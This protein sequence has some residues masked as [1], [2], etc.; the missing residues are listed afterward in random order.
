M[1]KFLRNIRKKIITE[2][3]S[4]IKNTNYIKYAFG[5][6]ILVM[7][8]ILLALQ[9]NNWNEARK[10]TAIELDI[11]NEVRNGLKTDLADVEYNLNAQQNSLKSQQI[12]INWLES[13]KPFSDSLSQHME[14]IH[15]GTF[16]QSNE[17]PY[18]TLKQLGMRTITNDSLRNQI[19]S[20]YDLHYQQYNKYNDLYEEFT[21]QLI[22]EGANDLNKV[23]YFGTNTKPI[24][25][26]FFRH[27]NR[28]KFYLKTITDFNE[29]IVNQTIPNIID[30]I[31]KTTK[32]IDEEI[33]TRS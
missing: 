11:L 26:E 2:N 21:I 15:Y 30:N 1:I 31:K 20:L 17:S 7:V 9:V 12:I 14:K 23:D 4:V 33:K 16:F 24:N 29:I 25:D 6:I 22:S 19:T 3:N 28:Y 27:N 10:A 5:E 8:G 13:N 18:Q 32:M